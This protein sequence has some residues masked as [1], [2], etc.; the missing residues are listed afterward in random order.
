MKF[1]CTFFLLLSVHQVFAQ[2]TDSS[3]KTELEA[4]VIR[5]FEHS[6]KLKDVPA[7]VNFLNRRQLE[8]FGPA[9]IV[10]AV[11]TTPGVRM[12]ERSPGSYRFSIRGSSLRSPFGVRN[13]KV[14]YNDIPFT[15][16]GG[17]TYLNNLGSYNFQS[18]EIIKGPG[19]SLYGAGT[20]GVLL[21][22][23]LAANE[24]PNAFAEY[25]VGSYGLHNAFAS[26]SIGK[27]EAVNKIGFQ[28]Q[29][30][31][32]YR[33]QSALKRNILSWNGRYI[34][35]DRGQLKTTFLYSDLFY[36]TPGAL[37]K[38]EYDRDP[39]LARP[40]GGGFPSAEQN[41]ASLQLK[42]LLAGLSYSH[43]FNDHLASTT[44]AYGI[45]TELRNPAIRNYG[46]NTEPHLGGRTSFTF[47]K[48]VSGGS[49][50][51]VAGGELQK[52]FSTLAVHQNR[53]GLRDSLQSLEDIPT[54]QS[55]LFLQAGYEYAG[56]ELTAG[57]S[58][59]YLKILYK[60]SFP[61]P[62]PEVRRDFRNEFAPRLA[63]SKKWKAVTVYSSVARGFSPPTAAELLPSGSAINLS[64]NAERGINYDLGFRGV[65]KD[66]SFDVN[67]F[68]FAL[69]NTIVQRRDAGGGDFFINAG[70]TAQRGIE[71]ALSYPLL[72]KLAFVRQSSI[73]LSHTWHHFRYDEFKQLSNGF[74]GKQLPGTPPHTVSTG[75]ELAAKNGL[76]GNIS[77]Y[78][79]DRIALNDANAEYADAYQL[80]HARLGFE[81]WVARRWQTKITIGAENLLDEKYS[82]G[83]DINAFGGRHYNA[84]QGRTYYLTLTL[85]VPK[86]N[87]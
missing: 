67:A 47:Q 7:A 57:G 14:Y 52:S 70:K 45:F 83:N 37:T 82:L 6:R 55:L 46:K 12:E 33:N 8:R 75:I 29:K 59:N 19:S 56:W 58:L 28:Y 77:Y 23:G 84:A 87:D 69:Q 24:R 3:G 9:A 15:D 81:K 68:L 43:R 49:I 51:L 5:A 86:G 34:T 63:L 20:G 1:F 85:Q 60:R 41:N 10:H 16:P 78:F 22:D 62:S 73:W 38:A 26:A 71:T 74:S 66:L 2:L 21:V 30:S 64:L 31:D 13:V 79:S 44:T 72:Q 11:N 42:T 65:W 36:E 48:P 80:V 18:I 35:S 27:A 61:S 25:T 54:Q 53:A 39:R 17:N 32:G 50:S 76:F 40:A 4:V